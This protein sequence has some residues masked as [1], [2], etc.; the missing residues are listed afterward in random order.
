M[1]L[2]TNIKQETNKLFLGKGITLFELANKV[3]KSHSYL[4]RIASLHED[5]PTPLEVVVPA[6]IV[7]KNFNLL[8]MLN[9]H[10]GFAM[11]KLPR[12]KMIKKD[13]TE[14]AGDYQQAASEAANNLIKFLNEPTKD[15]YKNCTTSLKKI[16]EESIA[17]KKFVDKKASNQFELF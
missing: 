6:M 3:N 17:V 13:E 1:D 10:C 12:T 7:K 9:W 8:Q 4:S 11:V 5:L 2:T 15:N 14:L 16:T